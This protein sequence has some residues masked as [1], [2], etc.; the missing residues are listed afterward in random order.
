M[1]LFVMSL[2][3]FFIIHFEMS[4]VGDD[5]FLFPVKLLSTK[6]ANTKSVKYAIS[7]LKELLL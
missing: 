5:S 4:F 1:A 7:E 3:V 6:L 2:C